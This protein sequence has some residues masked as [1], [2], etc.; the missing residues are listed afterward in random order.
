M[1]NITFSFNISSKR[2]EALSLSRNPWTKTQ[3][4]IQ[5]RIFRLKDFLPGL[6]HVLDN[7][8]FGVANCQATFTLD[9][10]SQFA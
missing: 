5:M 4:S 3:L 2:T 6:A 1:A 7:F 10:V 9:Q 8:F